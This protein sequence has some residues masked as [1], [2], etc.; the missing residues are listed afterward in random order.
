MKSIANFQELGYTLFV[1]FMHLFV[2]SYSRGFG[3]DLCGLGWYLRLLRWSL[4]SLSLAPA[5]IT[6]L[7]ESFQSHASG[8]FRL[9][10]KIREPHKT[11]S[12]SVD[13]IDPIDYNPAVFCSSLRFMKKV[14]PDITRTS[15]TINALIF[16]CYCGCTA[17]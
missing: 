3:S 7:I 4:C 10:S 15:P 16:S 14:S 6:L 2:F 12:S 9:W 11:T 5:T 13:S 8:L 1:A 17:G